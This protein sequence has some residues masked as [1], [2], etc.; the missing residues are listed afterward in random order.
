MT[1]GSLTQRSSSCPVALVLQ[2]RRAGGQG[3]GARLQFLMFAAD[4]ALHMRATL[5]LDSFYWSADIRHAKLSSTHHFRNDYR[6]AWRWF[7]IPRWNASGAAGLRLVSASPQVDHVMD[8]WKCGHAYFINTHFPHSCYGSWCYE[9][10]PGVI[11]R[12]YAPMV[13]A[14]AALSDLPVT[15]NVSARALVLWHLRTGD[16]LL[17]VEQ[18]GVAKL[19]ALIDAGFPLRRTRHLVLTSSPED[20]NST[21]PWLSWTLPDA[22]VVQDTRKA[23]IP[24]VLPAA[25]GTGAQTAEE[26]SWLT[27]LTADVVVSTGSSFPLASTAFA[28]L[29]RQVHL[30]GPPKSSLMSTCYNVSYGSWLLDTWSQTLSSGAKIQRVKRPY[31]AQSAHRLELRTAKDWRSSFSR[32]NTIP[33]DCKGA[34]FPEYMFKLKAMLKGLDSVG[35]ADPDVADLHYEM[36]M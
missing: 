20:L 9:V 27:M 34:A 1:V 28:P 13:A 16:I 11:D 33:L 19:R 10:M 23:M 26:H 8:A 4:V 24:V 35:R 36:W 7:G 2:S 32:K 18:E 22:E 31:R 17:P 30:Y 15:G 29:G 21:A 12:V 5:A 14:S 3:F 6:W 25:L